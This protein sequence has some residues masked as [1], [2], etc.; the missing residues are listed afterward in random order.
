M[1]S[2]AALFWVLFCS[3]SI[4]VQTRQPMFAML[5]EKDDWRD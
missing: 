1:T 5:S 4:G 3:T 2:R